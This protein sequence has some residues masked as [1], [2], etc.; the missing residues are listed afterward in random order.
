MTTEFQCQHCGSLIVVTLR[1]GAA[2]T[3]PECGRL[4]WVPSATSLGVHPEAPMTETNAGEH[5][6]AGSSANNEPRDPVS[7][8]LSKAMPWALS[9]LLHAALAMIMVL[10]TLVVLSDPQQPEE[11]PVVVRAA[12]DAQ[13]Q[14]SSLSF[15]DPEALDDE[16]T[17]GE[18]SGS[19]QQWARLEPTLVTQPDSRMISVGGGLRS[20]ID[21]TSHSPNPGANGLFFGSGFGKGQGLR[22]A[23]NTPADV[24][25]VLDR[26]GSMAPGGV[27]RS[28]QMELARSLGRLSP[29]HHRYH[30]VFFGDGATQEAPAGRLVWAT[31]SNREETVKYLQK[32]KAEGQTDPLPALRRAMQLLK[33]VEA[34][35]G[36]KR[37][38]F[39]FLLTDGV[40]PDNDAVLELLRGQTVD[41]RIRVSTFLY[42]AREREAIEVM[43]RIAADHGGQYKYIQR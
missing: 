31:D 11:I 35:E 34:T 18:G 24:V 7:E 25:Y 23:F 30:V 16:A 42:G 27:F 3:C 43:K 26:S 22:F 38:K 8:K 20:S 9:A 5:S 33:D 1:R 12:L 6:V 2:A 28:V 29:L 21:T 17:G 13:E 15:D 37:A 39:I 41:G 36:A 19:Q 4:A 10:A 40:F 32:V 14:D